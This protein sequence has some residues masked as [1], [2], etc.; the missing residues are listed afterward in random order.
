MLKIFCGLSA[1][2]LIGE[3]KLALLH[4]FQPLFRPGRFQPIDGHTL[5]MKLGFILGGY[6]VL[7][8]FPVQIQLNMME[9]PTAGTELI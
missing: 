1:P 9:H 4:I 8:Q 3:I 5:L 2:I 7:R 6:I